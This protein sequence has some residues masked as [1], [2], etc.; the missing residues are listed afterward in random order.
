MFHNNIDVVMG[1]AFY[2]I[3]KYFSDREKCACNISLANKFLLFLL[4]S[5]MLNGTLE[6]PSCMF[7]AVYENFARQGKEKQCLIVSPVSVVVHLFPHR[8]STKRTTQQKKQKLTDR[9]IKQI[10]RIT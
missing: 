5:Y 1:A 4:I 3:P 6:N 9:T 8:C 7:C 10:I 2:E